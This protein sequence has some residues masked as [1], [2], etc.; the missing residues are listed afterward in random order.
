MD[1]FELLAHIVVNLFGAWNIEF[2]RCSRWSLRD[3]LSGGFSLHLTEMDVFFEKK[4][5]KKCQ[6]VKSGQR[7]KTT[8]TLL[9]Y[10][11]RGRSLMDMDSRLWNLW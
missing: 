11:N 7:D 6:K 2:F 4:E 9:Y 1:D 10:K 8:G 5:K 3:W